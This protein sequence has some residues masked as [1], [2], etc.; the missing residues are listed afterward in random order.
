MLVHI[1]TKFGN[2]RARLADF[3]DGEGRIDPPT[4]EA[5]KS[6]TVVGSN[7]FLTWLENY[8]A[9]NGVYV[10]NNVNVNANVNYVNDYLNVATLW[11]WECLTW[12]FTRVKWTTRSSWGSSKRK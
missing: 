1:R 6:P 8:D 2:Y 12:I 11:S 5:Y 4:C 10:E 9:G 7:D 3:R